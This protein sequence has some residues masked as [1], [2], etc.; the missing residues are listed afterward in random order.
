M[1]NLETIGNVS[2]GAGATIEFAAPY[3]VEAVIE[4]T[5]PLLFHRWNV[6]AVEAKSKA[7]KGSKA[8]KEERS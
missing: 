5:A 3:S 8:K 2:N 6:D 1:S 7:A 4:G